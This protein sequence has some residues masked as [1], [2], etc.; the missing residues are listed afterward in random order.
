MLRT[1]IFRGAMDSKLHYSWNDFAADA[2]ALAKAIEFSG[3]KFSKI[4]AIPNGGLPLGVCLVNRLKPKPELL[5]ENP[6]MEKVVES[7]RLIYRQLN[8]EVLK[9]R[10][11]LENTLI[12]DDITDKGNV[13]LPFQEAGFYIVTIFR[14]PE[15]KV[16]PQ[17]WAR[18]KSDGWI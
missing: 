15:S 11:I 18:T 6:L 8:P 16:C 14:H 10:L 3:K 13:L 9:Q 2:E 4:F 1:V 12:V 17:S 5:L 7:G